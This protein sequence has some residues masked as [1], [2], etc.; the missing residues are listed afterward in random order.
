MIV[1]LWRNRRKDCSRS[2]LRMT[3]S[4]IAARHT[5]QFRAD[6]GD[7]Y[8]QHLRDNVRSPERVNSSARFNAL[9]ERAPSE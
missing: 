1:K 2:V 7:T 6:D 5:R 8:D 3:P 9:P 4:R